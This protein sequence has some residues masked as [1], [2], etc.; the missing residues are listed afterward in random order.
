MRRIVLAAALALAAAATV[1][2][3]GG[4]DEATLR[5]T[6]EKLSQVRSGQLSLR[7]VVAPQSAARDSDVGFAIKGRFAL[8]TRPRGLPDADL[9][10]TQIAGPQQETVRIVS[11]G[12]AAWARVG[13]QAFTLPPERTRRLRRGSAGGD[14]AT[15]LDILRI[16]RWMAD[17]ESSDGGEIDGA[18]TTR[19]TGKLRVATAL[20]DL[21]ALGRRAGTDVGAKPIGNETGD[22]LEEAK[23]NASITVH[24]GQQDRILRRLVLRASFPLERTRDLGGTIGR[25]R[26]AEV[27]FSLSLRRP[28]RP[29]QIKAPVN[30]QP[31]A[32]LTGGS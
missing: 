29:V 2:G 19:I 16:D 12:R 1:S 11:D 25:L 14:G 31:F 8:A 15:G 4:D 9:A 32:A 18:S 24:T 20:R 13:Q 26:G 7:F 27:R 30:P 5:E 3:C 21:L 17:P 22:K 10:Y 23:E 6:A 28:G